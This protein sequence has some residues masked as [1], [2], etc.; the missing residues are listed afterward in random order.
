MSSIRTMCPYCISP[1][2]LDPPEILLLPA[3]APAACGSYAYYCGSCQRVTVAAVS[4][5]AFTL[6]VN[7]GVRVEHGD[8]T[9][10]PP[11]AR[12]LTVDDLIDFHHLLETRDWLSRLR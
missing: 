10:D 4:R 3:S 11:P 8:P 12:P 2:D 7:A 9:P 5:D 6:L 1:V